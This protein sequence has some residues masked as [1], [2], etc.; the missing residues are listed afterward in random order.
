MRLDTASTKTLLNIPQVM[1]RAETTT[2]IVDMPALKMVDMILLF[3]IRQFE[4]SQQIA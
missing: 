2:K 1:V 4:G 3:V